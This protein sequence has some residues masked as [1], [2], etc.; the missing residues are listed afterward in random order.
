M[1]GVGQACRPTKYTT[2]WLHRSDRG[3]T[4]VA[5]FSASLDFTCNRD[6]DTSYFEHL[7]KEAR[8]NI[9]EKTRQI[10][11]N[12]IV[13]WAAA[14]LSDI[15]ITSLP[16]QMD[17]VAATVAVSCKW[18]P[19]R[20]QRQRQKFSESIETRSHECGGLERLRESHTTVSRIRWNSF[21]SF[22]PLSEKSMVL[23]HTD[24]FCY[25]A[26]DL[27]W[28]T[29]VWLHGTS[30][31]KFACLSKLGCGTMSQENRYLV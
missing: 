2:D 14:K 18:R 12:N 15:V 28:V 21:K 1:F 11:L 7:F 24:S 27:I 26:F 20:Q 10:Q 31:S 9:I 6:L 4:W 19:L 16:L 29:W 23:L 8:Y 17:L 22:M 5:I 30:Y 13:G 25:C 3:R